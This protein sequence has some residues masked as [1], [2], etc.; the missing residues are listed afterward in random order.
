MQTQ[1]QWDRLPK[2][3]LKPEDV[4][5]AFYRCKAGKSDT[6]NALRFEMHF[7]HYCLELCKSVNEHR[8]HP[9]RSIVFIIERP[10]K[11]EVFA[12]SFES[13]VGDHVVADK[14]MPLLDSYLLD[15]NYATRSGRGT[16]YGVRRVEAMM[17]ACTENWTKECWVMKTDI[18]SFFM[19]LDKRMLYSKIAWF[20]DLYYQ[21]EDKMELIYLLWAIIMDCPETHCARRCP[22]SRWEGLPRR[23]S[24]F[25]SDGRH[26]IPIGRL[27]SQMSVSLY[28][29]EL[30]KHLR[31]DWG[32]EYAGRYVDDIVMLSPSKDRL[33]EAKHHMEVWLAERHLNLHPRKFYL[34]PCHKGVNFVGG[35][36]LPGR[37][38]ATRR[39]IGFA[40][41]A[42]AA[43]NRLAMN[44]ATFVEDH[45]DRM[46]SMMNSYLGHLRHFAAYNMRR[47]LLDSVDPRWWRV[48]Y[49]P[50]TLRKVAVRPGHRK[51]DRYKLDIIQKESKEG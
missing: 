34:Q 27:I 25:N 33:F 51:I 14:I 10:V 30:D 15:D 23:K 42:V 12:P 50:G 47:R 40:F 29:D 26:G 24:L 31:C 3:K 21:G 7:E 18:E 9:D 41:D 49:S 4:F 16:L 2:G 5:E 32:V 35:Y 39:S 13:R 37:I 28:L 43:W 19:S 46:T 48:L 22:R 6:C 45:A 20:V 1:E 8:Y 11:R 44:G 17:Q 36:I 38:Y